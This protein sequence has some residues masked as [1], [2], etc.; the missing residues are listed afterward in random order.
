M[1]ITTTTV[2][3]DAVRITLQAGGDA[4][5]SHAAVAAAALTTPATTSRT[6]DVFVL[7]GGQLL[8]VVPLVRNALGGADPTN[9]NI[10][11]VALRALGFRDIFARRRYDKA[12]GLPLRHTNAQYAATAT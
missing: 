1:D 7:V 10:A 9:T 12:T 4:L 6:Y 3:T 2:T 8:P 5:L 11:E